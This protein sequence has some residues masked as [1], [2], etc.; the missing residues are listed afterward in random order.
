MSFNFSLLLPWSEYAIKKNK[1]SSIRVWKNQ[2][3]DIGLELQTGM[4]GKHM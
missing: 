3:Q 1:N 2:W 4:A